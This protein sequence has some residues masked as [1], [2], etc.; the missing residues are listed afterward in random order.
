MFSIGSTGVD[1][2]LQVPEKT[3]VFLERWRAS[4]EKCNNQFQEEKK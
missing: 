2:I 3:P 1:F 4:L